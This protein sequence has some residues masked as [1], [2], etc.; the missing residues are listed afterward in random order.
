MGEETEGELKGTWNLRGYTK[1]SK[2]IQAMGW[3]MAM[4]QSRGHAIMKNHKNP[5]GKNP[6]DALQS[7]H[8]PSYRIPHPDLE[9]R[10]NSTQC[11]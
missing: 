8:S 5:K 6:P 1:R 3:P 9:F 10:I 11:P 2:R 7:S 4:G